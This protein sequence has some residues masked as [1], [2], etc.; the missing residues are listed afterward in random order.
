ML[1]KRLLIHNECQELGNKDSYR[2]YKSSIYEKTQEGATSTYKGDFIVGSEEPAT[3]FMYYP[4]I[5]SSHL[6]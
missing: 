5:C 2:P 3:Y 6:L 4:S 1:Q